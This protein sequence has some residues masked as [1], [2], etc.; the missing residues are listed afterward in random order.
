METP[1][2]TAASSTAERRLGDVAV[3]DGGYQHRAL[4]SG[5]PAQRFW[6]QSKLN[7]LDWFFPVAPGDRIID[8]GCGSGVFSDAM[9]RRGADVLGI[10]A[11]TSAVDYATRTF[12]RPGGATFR[13]G[14]LDELSLEPASFDKATCLEVIEHVYEHQAR[15]LF[16]DLL[17]ILKPGGQLFVTTPN[18][19]GVWPLVEWAA[20]RF[21]PVAKMDAEQ[22]ITH[23]NRDSLR[24]ALEQS[25]FEVSEIR[26]YS[27]F[28]SFVSPVSWRAA[29]QLELLER[30]IDLPFGSVLAAVARKPW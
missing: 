1:P 28:A 21:S 4:T 14:F 20:D 7:L 11:N 25:G 22:H 18:Y 5:P 6:H 2:A 10:D 13:K 15:K 19:R 9:A 12:A 26:T 30:R 16:A 24:A 17:V 8:V 3:I 23:F 27:T 29:E